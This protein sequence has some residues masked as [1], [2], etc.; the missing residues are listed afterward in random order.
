M[1][2]PRVTLALTHMTT[3]A[4]VTLI[5]SGCGRDALF[6]PSSPQSRQDWDVVDR[7]E[8]KIN[9]SEAP[10][11]GAWAGPENYGGC[12]DERVWQTFLTDGTFT[13]INFNHDACS[14]EEDHTLLT[15]A[16]EWGLRTLEP[17]YKQAGQLTYNCVT[18]TI[19]A[20]YPQS[21]NSDVTF[22]IMHHD[23]DWVTLSQRAW[24][25]T[26]SGD[27]VRTFTDE[28]VYPPP[29]GSFV[30]DRLVSSAT[31]TMRLTSSTADTTHIK[32]PEDL[33]VDADTESF[34]GTYMLSIEID[35]SVE[36]AQFNLYEEA[37]E[38]FNIPV[39]LEKKDHFLVM[40]AELEGS[41]DYLA[42][43][44]YLQSQNINQ[45]YTML[46]AVFA[47]AFSRTLH[48]DLH[49]PTAWAIPGAWIKIED[50]CEMYEELLGESCL[51]N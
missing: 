45:K 9:L 3:L 20:R 21:L 6:E 23:D 5:V 8:P 44:D 17:Q 37:T 42:W 1:H 14:P 24:L 18:D 36:F 13:Q 28:Q 2:T 26:D 51:N 32:S 25:W 46:G 40:T 27:L 7:E 15:C 38:R 48:L 50:L 49:N 39:T 19:D 4:V 33:G 30:E 35:A 11:Q 34:F 47:L 12:I 10:V 29:E 16:G 31:V 41:S 22:A 43:S